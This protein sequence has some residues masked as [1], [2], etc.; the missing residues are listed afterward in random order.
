MSDLRHAIVGAAIEYRDEATDAHRDHLFDLVDRYLEIQAPRFRLSDHA[1]QRFKQRTG[2]KT[3]D[4]AKTALT[5]FL[6]RAQEVELEDRWRVIQL[7]NH[8]YQDARYFRWQCWLM[9]VVNNTVVTI[10]TATANRWKSA[11]QP[12]QTHPAVITTGVD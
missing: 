3:D 9:V 5:K 8:H 10:H 11:K 4:K 6:K 12:E 2:C 7:I 1:I